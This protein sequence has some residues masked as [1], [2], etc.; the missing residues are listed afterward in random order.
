MSNHLE[1]LLDTETC[2]VAFASRNLDEAGNVRFD[3]QNLLDTLGVSYVLIRDPE[4]YWYQ[5]GVPGLGDILAIAEYVKGLTKR[6]KRVVTLGVSMG[7]YA[8]LL[9]G[10]LAE[11]SEVIAISAQTMT[12]G[13]VVREFGTS[14]Y[15]GEA[16]IHGEFHD[17]RNY[18]HDRTKV[19]C[20]VTDGQCARYDLRY[21]QR[22]KFAKVEMVPGYTHAGLAKHLRDVGVLS[23][24]LIGE[25]KI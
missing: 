2:V 18:E 8:A 7:G 5:H 4:L 14:H 12:G 3:F 6:Y 16:C 24:I 21:A 13:Q 15:F 10:Y 17:I 11:V 9:F 22:L 19:T 23:S 20:Y 1:H 25:E